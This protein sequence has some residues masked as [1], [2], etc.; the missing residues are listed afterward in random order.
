MEHGN[1]D[2]KEY[3]DEEKQ[4]TLKILEVAGTLEKADT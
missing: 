3:I 2:N 4:I 1:K